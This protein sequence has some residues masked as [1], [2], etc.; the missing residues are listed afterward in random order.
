[1]KDGVTA[2]SLQKE[3]QKRPLEHPHPS[4]P[5]LGVHQPSRQVPDLSSPR[6]STNYPMAHETTPPANIT[7]TN[8]PTNA[9]TPPTNA[10][11]V[12]PEIWA[13]MQQLLGLL[14]NLGS[15]AASSAPP[16]A[17]LPPTSLAAAPLASSAP[18]PAAPPTL[19]ALAASS[20]PSP[21]APPASFAP[22]SS[23]PPPASTAPL[24]SLLAAS[25]VPSTAPSPAVGASPTSNSVMNT[26]DK[27]EDALVTS[28][29]AEVVPAPDKPE[30]KN[31]P[32][33]NAIIN[34]KTYKFCT[35]VPMD[36]P[37]SGKFESMDDVV[38]FCQ[39]WA[40]EHGYAVFKANSHRGKNVYIKCNRSGQFRGT[41]LNQSGR[42]TASMKIDSLF[43][44]KGS[45][46]TNR[47]L[48][49]KHWTLEI[50]N[51]THNHEASPPSAHAAH[52]QLLPEQVK[53]I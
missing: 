4:T 43:K 16:P 47:K 20:A 50:Q 10:V 51:A 9:P 38:S 36:P 8:P 7:G 3:L 53:E 19:L 26:E 5:K 45:V 46:P 44:V 15:L 6:H 33:P 31:Y 27:A 37:P 13:Q 21:A 39:M 1:M 24:T 34:L 29:L 23:A 28:D 17:S 32:E 11:T 25:S 42:N 35:G 49:T 52:R 18:S 40:K 30:I 41:L 22:E 14:P 2:P 12:S 48:Q